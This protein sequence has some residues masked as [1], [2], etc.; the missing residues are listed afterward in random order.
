MVCSCDIPRTRLVDISLEGGTS[1]WAHAAKWEGE[2]KEKDIWW[3]DNVQVLT[4]RIV[5]V[6]K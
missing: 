5:S 1:L 3:V 2:K 4:H 6:R